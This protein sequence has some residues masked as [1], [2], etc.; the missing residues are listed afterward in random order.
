MKSSRRSFLRISGLTLGALSWPIR[1]G[2]LAR[3]ETV[4]LVADPADSVASS[5]SCG[6]ALNQLLRALEQRAVKVGKFVSL[7]QAPAE[8]LCIVASGCG[9][10]VAMDLMKPSGIAISYDPD[11]LALAPFVKDAKHG[12]LACGDARGLMY[13]LLE[14]ADRVEYSEHPLEALQQPHAIAERPLN[15]LRSVGRLFTSDVEDKPWFYDR[16]MW[17]TYFSMLATQRFNR[18]S[19]NLGIGYDS[20]DDVRDAYFLFAYPFLLSVPGYNVRAV[21][22]PDEERNRNLEMLQFISSQA[23]A[24][25]IDF[26]LGIWTHGYR[27]G[28]ASQPNYVIEGLTS[29]NHAAYS[30]D[31]LAALLKACPSISGVT[32]RTHGES[33]VREGSYSFWSTVFSGLPAS[34]RK[35]NLD[36]HT[37]GLNQELIDAAL[38][39]GMPVTLSP[40]YWAEHMGLPYQQTAI[41]ELEMPREHRNTA[42]FFALSD[43]SRSFTRY[44]YADFLAEDRSYRVMFRIWP[45]THRL[46]LW[47][48]PSSAAAH[49]RA[50]TFCGCEGVEL[51]EPL[52]FK[53]RRA[54]GL[55]GNRCAYAEAALT[56]R[57]DWQKYLYTYRSWGRLIYNPHAAP[58]A[59]RRYLQK[60][61][62]GAAPAL[63]GALGAA[64]TITPIIT[65]AHMPSAANDA[66]NPEYYTNQSI[67]DAEKPS[68]YFDTPSPKVFGNVSPLDP[69]LFSSINEFA[70]ELM[71]QER[72]AKYSPLEV[73]QWVDRAADDAATHLQEAESR[74]PDKHS[75]E[76]RRAAIDLR[77]AIGIGRFF[78]AKFRSGVLYAAY[79][80]SGDRA[81]LE[82]ALRQYRRAR[83]IWQDFAEGAKD[84][85]VSDIT[86]GPRPD[87]RGNWLKRLDAIAEDV[88]EMQQKL[89]TTPASASRRSSI[90]LREFTVAAKRESVALRHTPAR[91]FI[92]G[93]PLEIVIAVPGAPSLDIALWYRRVNQAERY[94]SL[95]MNSEGDRF[96]AVIPA[97]YT[98]SRYPLQYYFELRRSR[99]SAWLF[100]GLGD[101]LQTQPY[102]VV[103][104]ARPPT[105]GT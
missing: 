9:S 80:Q 89:D 86:F 97:D 105:P 44:G 96:T 46:L 98:N 81:A 84:A 74:V 21:N 103:R 57:W 37:K 47:G 100:P 30:R 36:L 45:G 24:H 69:Q 6:W 66:Y 55:A 14:L 71:K 40:K 32:L 38:H 12:I 53:G 63:E 88:A 99:D 70:A 72:N 23:V 10:P 28:P 29:E 18:F 61:F 91:S 5:A 90:P 59:W 60:K 22:L 102:F 33:G 62:R 73:A 15:S 42:G 39:T 65:T 2:A 75:A 31:A 64:S 76:F 92:P 20:L 104:P 43:G 54:S 67:V 85:Y 27:W 4:S 77:I 48:D 68:P 101:N 79:E 11:S 16:D 49:A 95:K 25:G 87:Q 50:F 34:G 51:F 93:Q 41:R 19:L 52:S 13:A 94:Q 8:S 58:D 35:V 78:A 83:D 1:I 17:P 56:P 7:S 26:Q 3:G 82:E